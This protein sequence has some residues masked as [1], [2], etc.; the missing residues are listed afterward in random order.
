MTFTEG[1]RST[2]LFKVSARCGNELSVRA[3]ANLEPDRIKVALR[4]YLPQ[5]VLEARIHGAIIADMLFESFLERYNVFFV[6]D[7]CLKH[8]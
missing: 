1:L 3:S 4:Q 7:S 8:S 2:A 5:R 6:R